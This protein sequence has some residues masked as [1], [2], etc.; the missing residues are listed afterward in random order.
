[1]IRS[2]R[3]AR[4]SNSSIA[5]SASGG[6]SAWFHETGPLS[7]Y[8]GRHSLHGRRGPPAARWR[9]PWQCSWLRLVAPERGT[10][11]AL[12]WTPIFGLLTP[13]RKL[14]LRRA[15]LLIAV[16]DHVAGCNVS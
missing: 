10:C 7:F 13:K 5:T 3:R 11:E 8:S 4:D 6:G 15:R 1:M 9:A 14:E 12:C 2:S 16:A